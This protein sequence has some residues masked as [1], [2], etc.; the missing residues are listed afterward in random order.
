MHSW[1][2]LDV[3]FQVMKMKEI[4]IILYSETDP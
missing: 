3:V 4:H 2:I 1:M